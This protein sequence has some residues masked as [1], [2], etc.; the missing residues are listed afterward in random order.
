ML[1]VSLPTPKANPRYRPSSITHSPSTRPAMGL[2]FMVRTA[3]RRAA[4]F[5]V[6]GGG[7][8]TRLRGAGAAG[9]RA[10]A[11]RGRVLEGA[12]HSRNPSG[13]RSSVACHGNR[14]RAC[15]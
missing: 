11:L 4:V 10:A 12:W 15:G 3:S 8:G 2:T 6:G 14:R 1:R 7:D 9:V 5:C 13:A